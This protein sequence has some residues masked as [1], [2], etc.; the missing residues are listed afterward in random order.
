MFK[1]ANISYQSAALQSCAMCQ[2]YP[3]LDGF[4]KQHHADHSLCMSNDVITVVARKQHHADHSLRMSHD[5]ITVVAR[6]YQYPLVARSESK[7]NGRNLKDN[8][9]YLLVQF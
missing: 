6:F 1:S 5:A 9:I 2:P 8:E 3:S 4:P 7:K